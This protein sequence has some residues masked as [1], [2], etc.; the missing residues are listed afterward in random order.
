[1]KLAGHSNFSTTHRFYLCVRDDVIDRARNA[2]TRATNHDLA[3]IWHAP[4]SVSDTQETDGSNMLS[5][6]GL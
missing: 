4:S 6:K 5:M 1:M 3:R 2:S